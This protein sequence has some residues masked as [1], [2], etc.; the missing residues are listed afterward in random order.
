MATASPCKFEEAIKVALGEKGWNEYYS[1][2]EFPKQARG[3][4]NKPETDPI[5]YNAV[6]SGGNL[7][8]SQTQW[9]KLTRD[10]INQL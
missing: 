5:R 2:S 6:G 3:T 10:L 1:S 9:E 4:I 7:E 8:A